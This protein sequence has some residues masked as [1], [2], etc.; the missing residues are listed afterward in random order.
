MKRD[1]VIDRDMQLRLAARCA[2]GD[3]LHDARQLLASSVRLAQ[4]AA[5]WD[6]EGKREDPLVTEVAQTVGELLTLAAASSSGIRALFI[7]AVRG[8]APS[9]PEAATCAADSSPTQEA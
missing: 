6:P 9:E 1:G 2:A 3:L 7:E 5:A 8:S 4:A